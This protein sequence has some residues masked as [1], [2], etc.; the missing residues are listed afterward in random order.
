MPQLRPGPVRPGHR[1]DGRGHLRRRAPRCAQ[2]DGGDARR[3]DDPHGQAGQHGE[4]QA[5]GLH[6]EVARA[7]EHRE[8]PRHLRGNRVRLLGHGALPRRR[9]VRQDHRLRALVRAPGGQGHEGHL[10][11]RRAPAPQ[12]HRA[13]RPQAGELPLRQPAAHRAQRAEGRRLRHRPPLWAHDGD[14]EPRGHPILRRPSG[15]GEKI[16]QEVRYLELRGDPLHT[17]HRQAA[18]LWE[19]RPGGVGQGS[20]RE[21]LP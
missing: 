20:A 18:L 9:A 13:P 4:L 14:D 16:L 1:D 2:S 5:R 10:E 15:V 17:S 21:I 7:P 12:G 8:A 11:R 6:H 3:E 19:D